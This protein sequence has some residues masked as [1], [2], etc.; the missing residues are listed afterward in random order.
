VSPLFFGQNYWG[1]VNQWG[2][3]L[4]DAKDEVTRLHL[5]LLRVGGTNNDNNNYGV[6]LAQPEPFTESEI[7]TFVAY[8]RAVGAE[9]LLQLPVVKAA[10]GSD[11]TAQTARDIVTY[12]NVKK[13]YN[14]RYFSIGNEPDLYVDQGVRATGFDA[15][16]ACKTFAE[17]ADAVKSIEPNAVIVGPDLGWKY[18]EG[19]NDW[20]TPFLRDCASKIDIVAVH[21]YPFTSMEATEEKAY[22]DVDRFVSSIRSIRDK[23]EQNGAGSKPLAITETNI[24]Y[25]AAKAKASA[26]P[27]TF[28]AALWTADILGAGLV[29]GLHNLSLFCLSDGPGTDDW[30][31]GFFKA[32]KPRPAAHAYRLVSE[33]FRST[34]LTVSGAPQTTSAYAGRDPV[35]H[36]TTLLAINKSTNIQPLRIHYTGLPSLLSDQT[37]TVS[38]RSMLVAVL[39]ES[40]E[41]MAITTYSEEM[42]APEPQ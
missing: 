42:N 2:N 40:T 11:A 14:L 39:D 28:P 38:A 35:S 1:W 34:I 25:D 24:G 21:R 16:Q 32:G 13:G 36:K 29:E 30:A 4:P 12:V 26:S 6:A 10:D 7:D 18:Y 3:A 31:L 37:V 17:F 20:L 19:T 22:S 5:N 9:P 23:M 33:N 41:K 27:G 8:A 15:A